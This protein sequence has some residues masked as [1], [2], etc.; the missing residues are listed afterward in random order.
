MPKVTRKRKLLNFCDILRKSIAAAFVFYCV[1]K[2]LDILW[3]PV[4]FVVTCFWFTH[5]WELAFYTMALKIRYNFLK[6]NV[7]EL[8][9]PKCFLKVLD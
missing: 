8:A 7:L 5:K 2:D 9:F 1:V 6:G 4:M 3:G